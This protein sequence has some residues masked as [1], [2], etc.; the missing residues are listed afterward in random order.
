MGTRNKQT[1][2]TD[3]FFLNIQK[4][5]LDTFVNPFFCDATKAKGTPPPHVSDNTYS[6]VFCPLRPP[7]SHLVFVFFQT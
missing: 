1:Y 6:Q 2:L 4:M 5:C 3:F 7:H